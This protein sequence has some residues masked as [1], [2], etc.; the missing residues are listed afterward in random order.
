MNTALVVPWDQECG[1][2]ASV[3]GHVGRHLRNKGHSVILIHPGHQDR[4]QARTTAW[5]FEGYQIS[6]RPPYNRHAPVKSI[7]A[8]YYYLLPTLIQVARLLRQRKIDL[9]NIHYPTDQFV[10]FALLRLVIGFRLVL[11]VH[12]ADLFPG[13]H[14]K[15]RYS[16]TTRF[17]FSAADL[18]ITPSES[19]LNDVV[20]VFPSLRNRTR[21]I[22]NAV[23]LA[24][25]R[26]GPEGL[27]QKSKYIL[28]IA[29]HNSKKAV[30]I[31]LRAFEELAKTDHGVDLWLVGDGPLRGDLERLAR[32][33]GLGDRVQFLGARDREAVRRYL[34]DCLLFVLPSR[35]EP[36]GIAILEALA[37]RKAVV[38]TAVGGVPEIIQDGVTGVLVPPDDPEALCKAM[39]GLLRNDVF[40]ERL[41]EAGYQRVAQCFQW[42]AAGDRYESAFQALCERRQ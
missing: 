23:D 22:H 3:V 12:G 4:L 26:V 24:E 9:V 15:H 19:T 21:F 40:R 28:C 31:L 39:Q 2:V 5:H 37:S 36:F 27:P 33:L 7:A 20:T 29:N 42:A 1:G 14:P 32:E 41:A 18:V 10:Y 34:R 30:D 13:G 11:S 35:A 38:G 17:L 16:L 25:F 8:F 6:L